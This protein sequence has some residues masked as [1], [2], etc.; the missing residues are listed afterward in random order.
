MPKRKII[1]KKLS[2]K[3]KKQPKKAVKI[4]P[5]KPAKG[6][7]KKD[8][9]LLKKLI[10]KRREE[11]LDSMQHISDVA[12]RKSP[13]EA[14]GDISGYSLHMADVATDTYD[15]EFSLSLASSEQDALYEIEDALKRMEEKTFGFCEECH[16]LISKTRLKAV[17]Y[18]RLCLGCQEAKEKS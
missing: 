8:L 4:Q 16:K 9:T 18:T 3:A 7:S 17:P 1:K 15:R 11:I 5:Q 12:L 2:A 6:F 10:Y 14:S 13:K